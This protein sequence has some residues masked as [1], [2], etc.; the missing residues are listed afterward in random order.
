VKPSARAARRQY[1]LALAL[2]TAGGVLGFVAASRS[3]GSGRPSSLVAGRVTISGNDLLPLTPVFSL[4]AIAAVVAVLSAR[5]VGRRVVGVLLAGV[6]ASQ[7]G[8]AGFALIDLTDRVRSWIRATPGTA[9]TVGDVAST[10]GWGAVL[11]AAGIMILAAGL[12]ITVRGPSWPTMSAAYERP[13]AVSTTH[14]QSAGHPHHRAT[15]TTSA[16][17]HSPHVVSQEGVSARQTWDALDRGD[18]PT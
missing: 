1:W 17:D 13:R 16:G 5:R 18:D 4:A 2:L 7:V 9:S 10:P 8:L 14:R 3:W 12:L 6:G 11:I 15:G